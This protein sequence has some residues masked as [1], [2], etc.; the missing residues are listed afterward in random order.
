[1]ASLM[2]LSTTV[3]PAAANRRAVAKPMPEAAPVTTATLPAN[4]NRAGSFGDGTRRHHS[5]R[6][7]P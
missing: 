5:Y 2:S 4:E 7:A 3:A 6:S 1:M